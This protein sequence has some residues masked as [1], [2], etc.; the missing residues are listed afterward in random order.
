M[1][2][3]ITDNPV[4][5]F[6]VYDAQC[7]AF[8]RNHLMGHCAY[9]GD[10]LYSKSRYADGDRYVVDDA[11]RVV[12]AR[13]R[14]LKQLYQE[15]GELLQMMIDDFGQKEIEDTLV[16]NDKNAE[17]WLFEQAEQRGWVQ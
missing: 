4:H 9:C 16:D 7:A 1:S 2:V 13:G 15:R 3:V 10:A 11:G 12:C 17:R 5:D 8:E 6:N 14:C